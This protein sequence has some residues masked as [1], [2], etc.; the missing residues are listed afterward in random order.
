MNKI[1]HPTMILSENSKTGRSI[2]LPIAKHCTPTKNCA[3]CCYA[4]SGHTNR[5]TNKNKQR[6]VSQYLA[7]NDLTELIGEIK[8]H[9]AVRLSATGDL[10]ETHIPG[11]L[12]LAKNCPQTML[13]GMTRKLDI[14][15]ELNYRFP[16]LKM[17]VSVDSSSPAEVWDYDGVL[18]YGPRLEGDVVPKDSRIK[19]VFPY[20]HHGKVKK[21][22]VKGPK[23]CQAVWHEIPG[24]MVC[25]RCWSW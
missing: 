5:P 23:D 8:K 17:M 18:C 7:G 19:T 4:K 2:N 10:L 6:W 22:L 13:W 24:C 21:G 20:H 9:T 12:S 25:G 1:Y 3:K 14:A 11:V 15:Y 16:N